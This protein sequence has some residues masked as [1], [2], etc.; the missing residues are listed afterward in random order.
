MMWVAGTMSGTSLDGVDVALIQTDGVTIGG[1]GPGICRPYAEAERATIR[2]AFGQWHDGPAVP[3]A[4]RLVE[5]AHLAALAELAQTGAARPDLVGF[6][7]QT[8]AH[9]PARRRTHQAGD[10]ARLAQAMGM[11]VAWDFRTADVAAGGQG[12]PLVPFFHHAL[13]R[14]LGETAPVVFLNLGGVGNLSWVDPRIEDPAA[15]GACLAFDTGPANAPLND[16]VLA[17][18]GLDCDQDG[19][20]AAGGAPDADVI[21]V[22]LKHPYFTALPPKSLDRDQFA[23][24]LDVA[25]LNDADAAATLTALVAETV[26]AGL[27]L[28]PDR[29][30]RL[31]VCGGGRRNG[32]LMAMLGAACACPAQP[33]EAVGLD[34][35]M[36]EAQAFGYLAAR[37]SHG[38]PLSA[39]GTT[40]APAPLTGGKITAV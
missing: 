25:H 40:G 21:E 27:D 35:D 17:R 31:M 6:H 8:L 32:T 37:V 12:A 9:D 18:R 1:F 15:P 30:A 26:A 22:V 4:A 13:A 16:L 39:P 23:N 33:V 20:L 5:E 38:L 29:P 3:T 10:G 34:G 7:G 24:L 36:I 11:P 19:Q 2:A 14:W 28:L